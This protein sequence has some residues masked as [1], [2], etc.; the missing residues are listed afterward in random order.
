M[1]ITVLTF[2]IILAVVVLIHEFGHFFAAKRNGVLVEEFGFGF[3]PRIWGKKMGETLYSVNWI[4]LGG[5]VK[6]YGE[7]YHEAEK[8]G[9]SDTK[10]P[11]HRA[12]I[13]KKPWQKTLIIVGGVVMNFFLGWVLISFLFT[14]GIPSPAGVRIVEVA[15]DS[16]AAEAGLQKGDIIRSVD[17]AHE[18][19]NVILTADLVTTTNQFAGEKIQLTIERDGRSRPVR[20]T[21]RKNPPEGQGSLGVVIEQQLTT[22]K[23]SW[24]TAP[25]YGL[26]EAATMTTTIARELLKIPAQFITQQKTSVEFSGPVGIAKIVGEARQYGILAL[27]QLVAL[28]SLNLGVINILP[29]P[30]LD[31]GRLVF[32]IYEW[33]TGK[34]TN[35][36]FERYMNLIG[37]IILIALSVLITAYDIHRFWG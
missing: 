29:F 13:H 18:V 9:T 34:R 7:E 16:P 35:Q 36:I 15:K 24:Y 20:I 27:L 22:K 32:I 11:L 26:L 30:A 10:I 28:L 17:T 6:L 23:Y 33:V 8:K 25:F 2:V 4:P 37:F 31:G 3:P 5:F 21:P 19:V 14:Q 12:F 1:L